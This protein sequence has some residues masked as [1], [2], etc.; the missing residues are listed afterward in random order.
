MPFDGHDALLKI[1]PPLQTGFY[2]QDAGRRD[3]KF[4]YNRGIKRL[5]DITLVLLGISIVVPFVAVMAFLVSLDGH[6]PFYTQLRIGRNGK[7]FR[8]FK[9][10]T[11]VHNA[12]ALLQERLKT[13]PVLNA[14]WVRTQKLKEDFR[15]TWIGRI[16]RKTSLDELP[17]LWNVLS[18]SMS[19]VGPRPIM[20]C[21]KDL[22]PGEAYYNMR[23]GLTG[24]WQI[25]DRNGC[26]F[27]HRALFDAKYEKSISLGT[28]LNV[29]ART[30]SVVLRG[31]G[32]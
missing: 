26:E 8:I 20:P 2:V 27:R 22:Y 5:L 11:M 12:D 13:D 6:S 29:L 23:P 17:Q 9:I 10:R 4:G 14:E 30:F 25:S 3:F 28:D 24:F 19:L 18:G 21:Q 15:I 1:K 32:Y 7:P 31:T 16:L